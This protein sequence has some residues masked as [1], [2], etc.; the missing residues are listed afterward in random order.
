[1]IVITGPEVF[2]RA[3]RGAPMRFIP[4][5]INKSGMNVQKIAMVRMIPMPVL[6]MET[7]L[8][9]LKLVK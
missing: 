7:I 9:A 4:S 5:A 2:S 3:N 1:M 6:D 8:L